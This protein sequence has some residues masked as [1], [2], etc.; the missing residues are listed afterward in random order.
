MTFSLSAVAGHCTLAI[1]SAAYADHR[2]GGVK[3]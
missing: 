3:R 2:N 1:T